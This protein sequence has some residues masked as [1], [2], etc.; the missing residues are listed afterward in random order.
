M[1]KNRFA[2]DENGFLF[3]PIYCPDC[4]WEYYMGNACSGCGREMKSF[5]DK[6][7]PTCKKIDSGI[8]KKRCPSCGKKY[9]SNNFCL[10]CGSKIVE[11]CN[12]PH[13]NRRF[14]CKKES[15]PDSEE[16][17]QIVRDSVKKLLPTKNI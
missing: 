7:K 15:C 13:L 12:C 16:F 11:T 14:N 9:H 2:V 17:V 1:F 3:K 10:N 8:E 6:G 4:G 5:K